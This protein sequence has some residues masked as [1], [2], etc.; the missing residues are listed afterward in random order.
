MENQKY[1]KQGYL[2]VEI[3]DGVADMLMFILQCYQF[4]GFFIKKSAIFLSKHT[5]IPG[6]KHKLHQTCNHNSGFII[7]RASYLP[8][9]KRR[10]ISLHRTRQ[11][12]GA[13][14]E[15]IEICSFS[16]VITFQLLNLSYTSSIV[17]IFIYFNIIVSSIV[18]T[19]Y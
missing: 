11:A 7:R 2:I 6:E 5:T 15:G 17:V 3:G 4:N 19:Y 18:M 12:A 8:S 14:R 1:F 9:E 10:S 16:I 13:R